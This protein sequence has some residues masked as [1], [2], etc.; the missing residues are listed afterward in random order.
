MR[1]HFDGHL[2]EAGDTGAPDIRAQWLPL[3]IAQWTL[4]L[5][6]LADLTEVTRTVR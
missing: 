5:P 2:I 4:P 1:L 6:H 3:D